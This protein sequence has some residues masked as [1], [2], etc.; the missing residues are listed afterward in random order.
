M[1]EARFIRWRVR[2][3]FLWLAFP[4]CGNGLLKPLDSGLRRNDCGGL[5]QE[6]GRNGRGVTGMAIN[7]LRPPS[8][9]QRRL[10]SSG[11]LH[12]FPPGGNDH[13]WVIPASVTGAIRLTSR[14][15]CLDS[16]LRRNDEGAKV[17][18][19][20]DMAEGA[21]G[22]ATN[23]CRPPVVIPAKAGIQEGRPGRVKEAR[24]IRW[25]VRLSFL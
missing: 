13:S 12:T 7:P 24:F 23:P 16:G 4:R 21:V 6:F 17:R 9:F 8:S 25:R 2:L 11:L 14:P 10:E 5:D 22:L 15:A 20:P 1:K 19:L 3:S 18:N